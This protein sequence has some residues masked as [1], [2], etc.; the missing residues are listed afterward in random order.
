MNMRILSTFIAIF[1]STLLFAQNSNEQVRV[2]QLFNFGWK[3]K[4][5]DV[6][7]AQSPAFDDGDWRKLD[8]PHD[9][10]FEQPWDSTASR[11]RGF[12]AM[13]VGWYRKTFKADP[14]W[15]GK[16]VLLDF[17]GIML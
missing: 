1:C 10:Q 17:E 16:Q 2:N 7:N 11:G 13:G 15:K 9:F 6:S 14:T 3:F 4:A 5:G 8:I 12:K